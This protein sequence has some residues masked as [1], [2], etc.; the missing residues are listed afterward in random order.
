M[1]KIKFHL[2]YFSSKILETTT[3]KAQHR[4]QG[5]HF[6][7]V[8]SSSFVEKSLVVRVDVPGGHVQAELEGDEDEELGGDQVLP[9]QP[10]HILDFLEREQY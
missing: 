7:Q 3:L 1:I 5:Y 9:I 10:K 4:L 2:L 8:K 6:L